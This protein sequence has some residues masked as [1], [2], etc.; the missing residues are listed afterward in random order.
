MYD[1]RNLGA[2]L[3]AIRQGANPRDLENETLEFKEEDPDLKRSLG[4]IADAVVCLA[5]AEGG[6]IVIGIADSVRPN[7]NAFQGVSSKLSVDVVRLGIFERTRP[8]LSVPVAEVRESDA[9]LVVVEVPKGAVFYSNSSGTATRRILTRCA[10]FTP[11]EQRQASA[12]RGQIDWSSLPSGATLESLANDEVVRLRRLLVLAGRDDLARADDRKL[13]RDLRLL[14]PSGEVTRAALLL[15][16]RESELARLIP[17]HGYAYQYRASPGS[18]STAR[19]RGNRPILAAIE[20]L[21]EAVAV[22]SQVHPINVAGG[23]Q[24]QVRDY[25]PEA[26]RELVVNALIHRDYD[27]GGSLDIEHSPE[28]LTVTSPGG[29][30][31]GVTPDNILT[32]PSTPRQRLLVETVTVLQVAERTGQGIDR[33]YRELLRAG[34]PPPQISDDGFHVQVLVAG[35]TGNDSFSRFVADLSPDLAGDV[36]VLLGLSYLRER[37]T[38]GAPMLAALAQRSATEAQGVLDR[39]MEADLVLPSRR[40]ARRAFPTYSLSAI[41]LASLGRAVHYHVRQVDDV[42]KKVIDQVDEY[43]HVTN[44]T[45]RRLFDLD[46]YRARNLLRDLQERGILEKVDRARGGPGIKYGPGPEFPKREEPRVGRRGRAE[47][48]SETLSLDLLTSRD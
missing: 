16:G 38:I 33:A 45:L 47:P 37:R 36:E 29:L 39:L 23:V 2:V 9:R 35:G 6:S 26:I 41:G 18:E 40:T 28:S 19:A 48:Q 34:K 43:G 27:Q 3:D 15:L 46:L 11:E 17:A 1:L 24:L 25:P 22:R 12:A 31:F 32:H 7:R 14:T 8:P 5:N 13:L 20:T 42:D 21:L 30:V 4:L 10:P 44:Q